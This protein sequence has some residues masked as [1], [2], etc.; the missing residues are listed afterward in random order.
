VGLGGVFEEMER[1]FEGL[2]EHMKR[3][4]VKRSGYFFN[5]GGLELKIL[6]VDVSEFCYD[7][8]DDR[9]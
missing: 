7:R 3:E 9:E 2:M 4:F 8:V 6:K 1:D 5:C